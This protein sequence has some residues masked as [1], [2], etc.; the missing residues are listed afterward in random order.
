MADDTIKLGD[1]GISKKVSL[2]S[3]IT[4][5]IGTP[6]YTSPEII[7]KKIFLLRLIYGL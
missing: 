2:S 7:N 5:F 3:D 1:F 6:R 4:F